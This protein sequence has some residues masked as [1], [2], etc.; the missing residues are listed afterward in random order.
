MEDFETKATYAATKFP[1][2]LR[3]YVDDT[4]VIQNTTHRDQFLVH[5]NSIWPSHPVYH[6]RSWYGQSM[7]FWGQHPTQNSLQNFNPHRPISTLGQWPHPFCKCS[8]FNTLSCRA[9]TVHSNPLLP[10]KEEEHIKW[11]LHKCKFPSWVFNRHKIKNNHKYNTNDH[12][13]NQ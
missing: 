13:K 11:T 10:Q 9:R 3:R 1:R 5:I 4:F 7:T 8:V 12:N 6:R 2:F